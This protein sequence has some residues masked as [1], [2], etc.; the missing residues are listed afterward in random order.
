M[1]A[2][3]QHQKGVVRLVRISSGMNCMADFLAGLVARTDESIQTRHFC[4]WPQPGHVIMNKRI[5]T[6]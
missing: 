3:M 2:A 5:A 4:R 1:A 6:V